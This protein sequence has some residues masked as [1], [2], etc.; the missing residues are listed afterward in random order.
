MSQLSFSNE[1]YSG[2][3]RIHSLREQ[4]GN[5]TAGGMS[6]PFQTFRLLCLPFI[7][8]ARANAAMTSAI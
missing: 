6:S 7:L 8:S 3:K 5:E 2:R 4:L 1:E